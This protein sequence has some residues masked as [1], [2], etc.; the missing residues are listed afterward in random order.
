MCEVYVYKQVMKEL[1]KIMS[2][3]T[4]FA[5]KTQ[6][7]FDDITASLANIVADEANLAKQITD[8]QAQLAAGSSTLTPADQAALDT[9]VANATALASKTA[10]IAAAVP[11]LPAPPP[12]P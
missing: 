6:T 9:V 11:D 3:I 8:L 1:R 10:D 2:A 12:A 4:D 5:A 7:Q